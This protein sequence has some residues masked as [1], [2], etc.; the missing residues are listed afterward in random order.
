M[1][2][3]QILTTSNNSNGRS[4]EIS[5]FDVGHKLTKHVSFNAK[6]LK[7][8]DI[9]KIVCKKLELE[10]GA[11]EKADIAVTKLFND[12][13]GYDAIM[14]AYTEYSKKSNK[15][16]MIA[17]V[18]N[19]VNVIEKGALTLK[20]AFR[21]NKNLISSSLNEDIS[22]MINKLII[23]DENG[24]KKSVK[25]NKEL[26]KL[27]GVMQDMSTKDTTFINSEKSCELSGFGDITCITGNKVEVEDNISKL[28]G[29]FQIDT[30]THTWE[31]GIEKIKLKLNFKN[32][33]D[34]KEVNNAEKKT[35]NSSFSSSS[36]DWGHGITAE[37]LKKVFKGKLK[38][39]EN[40]FIK[41]SNLYKVNPAVVA[42]ISCHE[43]AAGTS[44]MATDGR[45]NFF[46]MRNSNGWMR[47]KSI[48]EG[49]K[50]GISNIS[51][52]YVYKGKKSLKGMVAD[53]AENGSFWIRETERFCIKIC[54]KHTTEL[55]W[56][57]GVVSDEAALKNVRKTFK[58]NIV[59]EASKHL[60][61]NK[62]RS[63]FTRGLWCADFVTYILKKTGNYRFS[64]SSS[65]CVGLASFYKQS[66]RFKSNRY[67]PKPGDTIFF[68]SSRTQ[69][70]TNHVGIVKL[71]TGNANNYRI[72]T[73]EGNTGNS[74]GV[75]SNGGMVGSHSYSKYGTS[76]SKIV[77]YG[78][79]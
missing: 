41:Y 69:N 77:G 9:V 51:R 25:E 53:Y 70:W 8:E 73:V 45:N 1:F 35:E 78:V 60:G 65:S 11:I 14:S 31:K 61:K 27:Y 12:V 67:I 5:A 62:F 18:D 76:Y 57:T 17:I 33:M 54:G 64:R 32:I 16:Y 7:G 10:M 68:K 38:G 47:F 50:R 48:E 59:T 20:I 44:K 55:N 56:G 37:Q 49:I 58:S 23:T 71:V 26:I 22:K 2:R 3:G 19:K 75:Y 42:A 30:D 52:R 21:E 15:K 63:S 4:I 13:T 43:S 6:N 28:K 72:I 40:I 34:E 24:N 29:I 66:N 74:R 46:G 36:S 39:Q 79:N